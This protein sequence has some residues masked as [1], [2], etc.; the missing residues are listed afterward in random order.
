MIK[1][2]LGQNTFTSIMGTVKSIEDSVVVT[3]Y[4]KINL[5]SI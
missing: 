1:L 3:S 5:M 2:F 4:N